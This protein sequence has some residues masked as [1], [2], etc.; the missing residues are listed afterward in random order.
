MA[1]PALPAILDQHARDAAFLWTQR[2]AAARAPSHDFDALAAVD[3]RVEAHLDGLR[4]GGDVAWD[5]CLRALDRARA[6]EVFAASAIAVERRDFRG[7]A[8]ALDVVASEPPLARGVVS[9]L[10]WAARESAE[11]FV[12]PLLVRANVAALRGVGIAASAA[13]RRDP[14]PPLHDA[15]VDDDPALRA[16]AL[17]AV[18]E[19]GKVEL[20]ADL[21]AAMRDHDPACRFAAA[22]SAA[23]FGDSA[24]A[25]ALRAVAEERSTH[26]D[27]ACAAAVIAGDPRSS[28][29]WLRSLFD[30]APL[31]RVALAGAAALGD[32]ALVP[33]VIAMMDAPSLARA[34][35]AA[36]SAITGAELRRD[37]LRGDAPSGFRSGPSDDP[38]DADVA[39]DRDDLL[40]W[41]DARAVDRAWSAW[42]GRM[43]D[44]VRH[45]LGAPVSDASLARALRLGSQRQRTCVAFEIALQNKG[46]SLF[47]VRAP[48][49]RQAALLGVE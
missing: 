14:G 4:I 20:L 13:H 8:E 15:V 17:E 34:A 22:W 44:G 39:M 45:V 30:R 25:E 43:P 48:A 11:P 2:D 12:R 9:A 19:L 29:A 38:N 49:P 7:F 5:L 16:R 3:E 40:P 32:P 47:E 10:G 24:A 1:R 6:G 18:G 36:F 23:L 35:G 33:Q 31:R 41:P 27:R 28:L 26:A 46:K 21:R 42:R 37:R